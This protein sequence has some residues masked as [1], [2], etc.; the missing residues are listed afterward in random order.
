[1]IDLTWLGAHE[2]TTLYRARSVSPVDV[3]DAVLGRL[4]EA[5][6]AINAFVTVTADQARR[7]ARDAEARYLRDDDHPPLLGVPVT[8]KDLIDTAG[9]RTTYGS[10]THAEHV[11]SE[12][13]IAWARLATAGAILIGKTTTPEFGLLGVTESRLTGS[14]S[15]PWAPGYAAGGSSG[16]AG[17]AVAAGIGPIA[18]GSDGGGSIRVPASLCGVVGVKPTTGRIPTA[19]NTDPDSTE[20][21][22]ARRVVDAALA[23]DVTVG[24]HPRDRFSVPATGDDYLAA[25]L[26]GRDLTGLRIATS[27]DLGG[28]PIDPETRRAFTDAVDRLATLGATV[29]QV[30]LE[31]PDV[32]EF[33]VAYWGS[34]YIG[35]ADGFA[36]DGLEPWPLILDIAD[37]ARRLGPV[38]VGDALRGLKTRLYEQYADVFTTF[39]LLVCP[40]TPYPAFPHSTEGGLTVV[41]GQPIEH[42]AMSLHR[43]TE[44][45]SHAGLPAISVPAGFTMAGL[46]IGLQFIAPL[47]QDAF[48]ISVAAAYEAS[49]RWFERRPPV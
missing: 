23:L 11:P 36:Q 40:T 14:T 18:W 32:F 47:Y 9:V 13:G 12:D 1:M 6:P 43:L 2:L 10:M 31:L 49:S 20:G 7:Q 45:P 16:G 27:P 17:A 42:P 26:S 34:E 28:G 4:D 29:E 48:L 44:S 19:G 41:D 37:R 8:V 15:T 30:E 25:A 3:I 46:P 39:D 24:A 21:P 22:L 5:E 38:D 33:F 35:V